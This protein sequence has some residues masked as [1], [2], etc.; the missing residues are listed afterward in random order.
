MTAVRSADVA[1][2]GGGLAGITAALDVAD[3]GRRVVLIERKAH[4]G[5]LTWSFERHGRWFDNG[6]HV[7]LRCCDAYRGFLERI[8]SAGDVV[9]QERLAVP[10]LRPGGR[11]AV[12]GRSKWPAP[13]HL[14]GAMARY[15]H[16]PVADR[17][18][19]A[20]AVAA[21]KRLDLDDRSLDDRSFGE[22]LAAHHQSRRA[23]DALWNLIVL[24]TVNL[25]A[26]EASLAMAAKV[27][28]TGLLDRADAGDIGWSA[29]PLGELHGRRAAEALRRAGVEVVTGA[30]VG[31]VEAVGGAWQVSIGEARDRA[32]DVSRDAPVAVS[33]RAALS[34]SKGALASAPPRAGSSGTSWR[35]G[36]VV[37]ATPPAV[38]ETLA[39]AGSLPAVARLGTSAVV[40]VQLVFDR[41]VTDLAFFA[42]IDSPVQFVFDRSAAGGNARCDGQCLALSLSGADRYLAVRPG[43]LVAELTEHLAA[44]VPAVGRARLVDAVVTKERAATFRAGAGS[45]AWRPPAGLVAEGVAVAGAWCATGW[46]ATMESAVRSG[47]QAAAAVVG[48]SRSGSSSPRAGSSSP[49]SGSS[50]ARSGSFGAAG[51]EPTAPTPQEVS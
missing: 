42:A 43:T 11:R 9:I 16:L 14:A 6:Q 17:I 51:F 25:P 12:I 41:R 34:T 35:A 48:A 2:I 36:A 23:V 44:L 3:S 22:W 26:S 37:L 18:R 47:H 45:G 50:S 13:L 10:V 38:T 7:F 1:V 32:G 39:P 40:D 33:G 5:G 8:G 31:S 19:L 15:G 30:Q 49:R 27:F 21:L 28:R 20:P 29:V 4:L 46:P 24:P